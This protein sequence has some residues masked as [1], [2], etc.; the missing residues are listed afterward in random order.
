MQVLAILAGLLATTLAAGLSAAASDQYP[1]PHRI[2]V[3]VERGTW[4]R[5][6]PGDI[7]TVLT[8]VADVLAPSFP[9]H[10]SDRIVVEYSGQGPRVLFERSADGAYRVFLNVQDARWDQFAYQFSHELCHIFANFEHRETAAGSVARD[11]QWFE[12]TVCEAVS[13]YTL[14]QVALSWQR[15]P[16]HPRWDNYAP[17][18][19]DYAQRLQDEPHR[20][21]SSNETIAEWYSL[22][23]QRLETDPYLRQENE[24]LASRLLPWLEN[25]P[26]SLRA[27]GYLNL[28]EASIQGNFGSFLK[29]W[30]GD[31]PG[32]YRAF[33][34]QVIALFGNAASGVEEATAL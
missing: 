14:K 33:I 13:I 10:A 16:P 34:G 27:I 12:E 18:F 21:L 7:E 19:R 20:R 3:Q 15:S 6:R 25:T 26:G 31:C 5:A 9:R 23:R 22:N 17:V 24:F 4:G 8:S 2:V 28:E 32:Q 29:S 1:P 11:S 30:Y